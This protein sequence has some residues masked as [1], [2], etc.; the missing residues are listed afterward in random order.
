[1]PNMTEREY[2]IA[3]ARAQIDIIRDIMGSFSPPADLVTPDEVA[4]MRITLSRMRASLYNAELV[5]SDA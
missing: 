1:M 5:T 4:L 2:E 3:T